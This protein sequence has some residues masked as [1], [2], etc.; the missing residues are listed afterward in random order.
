MI[1]L[2]LFVPLGLLAAILRAQ[3]G[4][5][6]FTPPK[7]E[8]IPLVLIAVIIQGAALRFGSRNLAAIGLVSSQILLLIFVWRN[9]HSA[10]LPLLGLGLGLNLLVI[11]ANGGFMPIAPEMVEQIL[12]FSHANY[13]LYDR[14]SK[15]IVLPIT[16]TRLWF[17]SDRSYIQL[18]GYRVAYSLGD[19]FIAV[20]AFWLLLKMS[21]QQK[22]PTTFIINEVPV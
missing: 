21:N 3:F 5:R 1:L 13:A 12:P 10:G 2:L 19:V 8:F 14:V 16:E 17:L 4:Q 6:Y 7:L 11:V 18:L 22:E 20:G 15:D 9:R